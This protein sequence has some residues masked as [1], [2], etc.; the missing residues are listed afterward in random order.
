MSEQW[1]RIPGNREIYEIS[2]SG[3]I[4]TTDRIGAR[5]Y[6]RNYSMNSLIDKE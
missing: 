6:I 3:I 5:S 1:K 4:R 2:S